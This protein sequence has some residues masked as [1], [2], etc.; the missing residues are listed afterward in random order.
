MSS[1]PLSWG[2]GLG[3]RAKRCRQAGYALFALAY[4]SFASTLKKIDFDKKL[5]FSPSVLSDRHQ[6]LTAFNGVFTCPTFLETQI[7]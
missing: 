5:S 4:G 6:I 7:K 3:V 2:E 1:S